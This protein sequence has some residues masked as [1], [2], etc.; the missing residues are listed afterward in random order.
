[1]ATTHVI[2]AGLAG[3]A[4]ATALAEAGRPVVLHEGAEQAGGRCRSYHDR[5][6]DRPLDN[7]NHLILSGNTEVFRYLDRL[8]ARDRLDMVSPAQVPFLDLETGESWCVRP[9]GR[10]PLWLMNPARRVAGV[11]ALAHLEM[12]R[13]A[14]AKPQDTV[15]D[16]LDLEGLIGRR[17]WRPLAVSILNT[18][19][20]EASARLLW[21]VFR[22]TLLA[23]EATCRPCIAREGLSDALVEPALAYLA[24]RGAG[25]RFRQRVKGL[26][27]GDGRVTGLRVGDGVESVGPAD[28]VVLALPAEQAAALLPGLAAPTEHRAILNL[29]Y[30]LDRPARL[31]GGLPL[32]GLVGGLAEWLFVRGDV[33]SVTVSA[34][35]TL[36]DRP[37][38][39]L[40]DLVWRDVAQA[41]GLSG[42]CPAVRVVK[43][44]RATFASTPAQ[45]ANR[46][47][48]RTRFAN[49][50]LAGDWTDTGL[51]ATL[52]G[53]VQSG[54]LAAR[55][56]LAS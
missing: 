51:P 11:G 23:G 9:Q 45:A 50:F 2:G 15:A 13:L 5:V 35:E 49:L 20:E 18:Q 19:P 48:A 42:P 54:H 7:G 32:L 24:C 36:V 29:H 28:A 30:R 55:L 40:A 27:S 8:G 53:A 25:V 16:R 46:P 3:L 47:G 1:M 31:P 17:L 26:E 10:L 6:L 37:A 44:K 41:M 21:T 12:L 39:E 43:E 56:A 33:V 52:E 14:T 34:A 4:A 38:E 22:R